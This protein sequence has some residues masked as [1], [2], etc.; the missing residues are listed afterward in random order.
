M[1]QIE[2]NRHFHLIS[3]KKNKGS[4]RPGRH[5]THKQNGRRKVSFPLIAYDASVWVLELD[6]ALLNI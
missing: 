6:V 1:L 5:E 4:K 3:A 2:V